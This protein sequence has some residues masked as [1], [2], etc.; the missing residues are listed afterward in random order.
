M[1]ETR[2]IP[3]EPYQ[4]PKYVVKCLICGARCQSDETVGI[5]NV[6]KKAVRQMRKRG[7]EETKFI[8]EKQP[9]GEITWECEKCGE[10]FNINSDT[11]K[12]N[13]YKYCPNCG[14]RIEY[15]EEL[16]KN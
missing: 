3:L 1:E 9:N 15:V 16:C 8:E 2:T 6:C 5:C 13:G 14:R 12:E 10:L 11:P 7:I 4:K